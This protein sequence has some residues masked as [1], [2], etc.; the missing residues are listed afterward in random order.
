VSTVFFF[1]DAIGTMI[2][3]DG[4]HLSQWLADSE[5]RG[6]AAPRKKSHAEQRARTLPTVAQTLTR[7]RVLVVQSQQPAAAR[8][9]R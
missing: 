8:Q 3:P 9:E 5:R 4:R 7:T 1:G 2:M 6:E